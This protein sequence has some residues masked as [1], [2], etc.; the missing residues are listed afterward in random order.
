MLEK[1]R[2]FPVPR[3]FV[4]FMDFSVKARSNIKQRNWILSQISEENGRG[5]FQLLI[6][7]PLTLFSLQF[8][9]THWNENLKHIAGFLPEMKNHIHI[10][11]MKN[12]GNISEHD[13]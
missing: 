10:K 9:R 12:S 4:A 1:G 5:L 8:L 7:M 2:N 6:Q 3:G 13:C 11:L